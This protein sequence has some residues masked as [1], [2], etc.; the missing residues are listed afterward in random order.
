MAEFRYPNWGRQLESLAEE[1]SRLSIACD[2][3]ILKEGAFKRILNNDETVCG[4]RNPAAFTKL[5][6]ALM[7]FY[8]VEEKAI[9]RLGAADVQVMLDQVRLSIARLRGVE[10]DIPDPSASTDNEP[11][12]S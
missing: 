8:E 9:E 11:G 12:A 5:R 7:A 3:D 1:L 6:H 2:I 4:H 10:L